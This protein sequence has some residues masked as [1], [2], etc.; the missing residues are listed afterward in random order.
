MSYDMS[1]ESEN[2]IVTEQCL[3]LFHA[4]AALQTNARRP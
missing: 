4:A 2:K 3:W 1:S